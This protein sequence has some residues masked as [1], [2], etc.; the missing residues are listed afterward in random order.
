MVLYKN[1]R[2]TPKKIVSLQPGEVFVFGSNLAGIHGAGAAKMA[3]MW[4]AKYGKGAGRQGQTFAIPTKDAQIKTLPIDRIKVFVDLFV[5]YATL[6]HNTFLVTEI[7]C[8]LSGY[9]PKD[10]APLFYG[11]TY[12][13]N[14]WLPQRFWDVLNG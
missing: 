7:G 2:V 11:C 10:L 9:E 14:V 1:S 8:G 6:G 3:M 13:D 5:E 12:L 4:G